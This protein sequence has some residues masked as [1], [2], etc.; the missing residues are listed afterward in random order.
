MPAGQLTN[1]ELVVTQVRLDPQPYDEP[2]LNTAWATVGRS[3]EIKIDENHKVL[4]W[5]APGDGKAFYAVLVIGL[6]AATCGLTWINLNVSALPSGSRSLGI[7]TGNPH[8]EPAAVSLSPEQGSDAPSTPMPNTE[9]GD[10]VQIPAAIVHEV[11]RD[12]IADILQSTKLSTAVHT[13]SF[14]EQSIHQ[15]FDQMSAG[16]AK[17]LRTSPKRTPT[18]ETK[19]ATIKGWTVRE[20]SNGSAIVE[21]PNGV[22]RATPGATVP[23]VGT[24]NSIV[25]WGNRFIVAT[26]NGLIS[27]P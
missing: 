16:R 7:S 6:L 24:V 15:P 20:V 17:E 8:L 14:H 22:W 3:S 21:G 2:T 27:T 9:K 1:D 25:G 19:P 4:N 12:E 23:G 5:P 26:S 13:M 10:R 18:P 11:S